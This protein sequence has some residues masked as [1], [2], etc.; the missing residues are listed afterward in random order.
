VWTLVE[1]SRH[2]KDGTQDQ[3][4]NHASGQK[5]AAV[6]SHE[7][8]HV[9]SRKW[10]IV[11]PKRIA[12]TPSSNRPG[13]GNLILLCLVYCPLKQSAH[14]GNG[15]NA[16]ARFSQPRSAFGPEALAR[17]KPIFDDVWKELISE[18]VFELPSFDEGST[19]TRLAYKVLTFA[20]T[21]WTETQMRQL[22]L[23][24]FRNEVARLRR[25]KSL[26]RQSPCAGLI[27]A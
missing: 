7:I 23:R 2:E 5:T 12:S 17:L 16:M 14:F 15:E 10:L 27:P 22:L 6:T 1:T 11:R 19:R 21:D 18:G 20:S 3:H 25:A 26:G 9:G 24:A 13:A 4:G 8:H